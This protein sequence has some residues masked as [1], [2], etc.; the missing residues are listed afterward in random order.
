[1]VYKSLLVHYLGYYK[2][3]RPNFRSLSGYSVPNN[4]AELGRSEIDPAAGFEIANCPTVDWF[5]LICLVHCFDSGEFGS[6]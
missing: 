1:M 2:R 4:P 6:G 5:G 3:H